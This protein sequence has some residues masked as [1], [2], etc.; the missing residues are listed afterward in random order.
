MILAIVIKVIIQASKSDIL[1]LTVAN[2]NFELIGEDFSHDINLKNN[3]A[4]II[5]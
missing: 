5:S 3:V 4:N 2:V 1:V